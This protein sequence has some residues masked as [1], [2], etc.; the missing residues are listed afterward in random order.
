MKLTI[1]EKP[2]EIDDG[3]YLAQFVGVFP[4][5]NPEAK[6]AEGRLIGPQ[7]KWVFRIAEGENSGKEPITMTSRL[8]S[9][10]NTCGKILSALSNDT[11][12][13]GEECDTNRFVNAYYRISVKNGFITVDP[14]PSFVAF[15]RPNDSDHARAIR[16]DINALSD[17]SKGQSDDLEPF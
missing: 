7:L 16:D 10:A 2:Y 1:H 13:E 17:K 4:H 15:R 14:P 3:R 12:V 11:A 6:T 9:L 5:H 8:P